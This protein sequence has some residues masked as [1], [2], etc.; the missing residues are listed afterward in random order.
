MVFSSNVYSPAGIKLSV[1]F[2]RE[3]FV[4]NTA[5]FPRALFKK[6]TDYDDA[7]SFLECKG[8]FYAVAVGEMPGI[9]L[10]W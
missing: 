8:P 7:T 6:C 4:K 1:F 2:F 5:D 9:Y 10:D 3:D